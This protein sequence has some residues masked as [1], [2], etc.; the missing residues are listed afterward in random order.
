M[1]VHGDAPIDVLL[2][3]DGFRNLSLAVGTDVFAERELNENTASLLV[4]VEFADE[5]DD[6]LGGRFSGELDVIESDPRLGGSLGLHA[7][8]G[9]GVGAF[10]SLDDSQRGLEPGELGLHRLDASG[11]IV[12]G[13]PGE[14]R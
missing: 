4:V 13:G 12:P 9:G 14:A 6:L 11:D 7:D 2:W 10:A 5:L 3:A 8:V 1:G